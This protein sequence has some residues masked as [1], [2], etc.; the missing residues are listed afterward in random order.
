MIRWCLIVLGA[1]VIAAL[2]LLQRETMASLRG[3]R[4]LLRDEQR[5]LA[6]LRKEHERLLAS[7][8]SAAELERLRAD[9]AALDRLR[10]EIEKMK[11]RAEQTSSPGIAARKES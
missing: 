1:L 3:E 11:E 4:A 6:Q 7:Q 2:L 8:P 10:S 5:E 9:R